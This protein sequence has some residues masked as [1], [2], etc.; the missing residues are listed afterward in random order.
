M[1]NNQIKTIKTV[2]YL[3]EGSRRRDFFQ[4]IDTVGIAQII[5]RTLLAPL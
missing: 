2:T 5:S 4:Y 3:P 1:S